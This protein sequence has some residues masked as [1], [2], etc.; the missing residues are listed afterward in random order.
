MTESPR[1]QR[2]TAEYIDPTFEWTDA[3]RNFL[4][5]DWHETMALTRGPAIAWLV[6]HGIRE[7]EIYPFT[8]LHQ[9]EYHLAFGPPK[10]KTCEIPWSSV[11][12][13]RAR[14]LELTSLKDER[15]GK[16]TFPS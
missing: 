7:I 14:S 2:E 3:E 13:F 16:E 6:K 9:K 5:N 10:P 1:S 8:T 4:A 15:L 12:A 11:E